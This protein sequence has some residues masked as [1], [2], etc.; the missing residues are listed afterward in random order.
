VGKNFVML[1]PIYVELGNGKVVWLGSAQVSGSN[2]L[3]QHVSLTGLKDKPK[4]A[5]LAYYDDLLGTIENH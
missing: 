2:S 5:L 1:V 3:E 4:R